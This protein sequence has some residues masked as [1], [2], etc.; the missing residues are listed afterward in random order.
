M[1]D[2]QR[3]KTLSGVVLEDGCLW[4]IQAPGKPLLKITGPDADPQFAPL[5][6]AS[7][8]MF[9]TLSNAE[10]WIEL[11]I[12][13]LE[14]VGGE[15]AVDSALKMQGAIHATKICALEGVENVAKRKK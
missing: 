3:L 9:Q 1:S 11:L 14:S 13:W 8:V 5:R 6:N 2:E 7:L 12:T 10:A 15:T 4:A